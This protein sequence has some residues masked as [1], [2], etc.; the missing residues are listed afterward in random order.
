MVDVM[1][2]REDVPSR[3]I[4]KILVDNPKRFYGL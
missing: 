1:R 4:E 3:V 2:R